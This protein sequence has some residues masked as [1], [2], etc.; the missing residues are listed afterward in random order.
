MRV[1][2]E[3]LF[4]IGDLHFLE[5]SADANAHLFHRGAALSTARRPIAH[6]CCDRSLIARSV[7][8]IV[9]FL[10][11]DK[12]QSGKFANSPKNSILIPN[13]DGII[14]CYRQDRV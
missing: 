10:L 12:S 11:L 5:R 13:R 1:A 8:A 7:S 9:N 4:W 3:L 2:V 6:L 14:A